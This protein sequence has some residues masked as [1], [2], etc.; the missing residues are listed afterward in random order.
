MAAL[1]NW[2]MGNFLNLVYDEVDVTKENIINY[3]DSYVGMKTYNVFNINEIPD[4]ENKYYYFFQYR[5][6]LVTYFVFEKKLPLSEEV[7][8]LL[9]NDPRFNLIL[10]NDAESDDDVLIEYLDNIFKSIGIDTNKIVVINCNENNHDLKKKFKSD[11]ITH[12][13]NNGKLAYANEL[14]RFPYEFEENRNFL[15]MSYN[16][17]VK[18][19]RFAL[20]VRLMKNKI[21]D[22]VDWSW[23][24]GYQINENNLINHEN[25]N[26]SE[27]LKKLFTPEEIESYRD[28]IIKLKNIQVKKS[29]YE[30]DYEVDYP[31]YR[32][33]TEA[34]YANNPYKNSYINI[35]T[36]TN[37]DKNDIILTSEKSF[38]PLFFSQ[39]PIIMASV[40]HVKKIKD[41]Y[42]FDFF[43]DI[44]D[45]S[46]DSEPNHK[47]RFEMIINEII[48]LNEKKEEIVNFFKQNKLRFD[49][50]VQIFEEI[51][52]DKTDYNFYKSLI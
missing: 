36:E 52:K 17:H 18:E 26:Q 3:F 12:S 40:N 35:V 2:K 9:K 4:D 25:L 11:I 6:Y 41:R 42:G 1:R 31:P 45:H 13:T 32:F 34:S 38:I 27:I 47:K 15:F 5:Y 14:T 29:V 49:K 22:N 28:E 7:I 37:F 20:L 16:R 33:D 46:Y 23:I 48:R 39:I 50:N 43:D 8:N 51:K 10:N 30:L 21:L 24:R 19:H 44:V